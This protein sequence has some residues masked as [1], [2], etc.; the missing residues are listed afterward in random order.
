MNDYST[1]SGVITGVDQSGKIFV[2]VYMFFFSGLLFLFEASEVKKTEFLD[3]MFRR[4]FGFLYNVMG[5]SLF[6]IL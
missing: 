1:I 5:K 6:I 2:G 3:H 4:N